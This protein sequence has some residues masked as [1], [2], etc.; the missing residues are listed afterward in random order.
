MKNLKE[1]SRVFILRSKV[2]SVSCILSIGLAVVL[3]ISMSNFVMNAQDSYRQKLS[4][5]YGD[6]DVVASY[7]GYSSIGEEAIQAIEAMEDVAGTGAGRAGGELEINGKKVYA[8][9]V[10]D[11]AMMKSRYRYTVNLEDNQIAVNQVLAEAL[12]CKAGDVLEIAGKRI[13]VRQIIK[14][15]SSTG[16]AAIALMNMGTLSE[17]TEEEEKANFIMIKVK[18]GGSIQGVEKELRI[19][20][21]RLEL[22]VVEGDWVFQETFQAFSGFLVILGIMVLLTAGFMVLGIFRGFLYKYNQDMAVIRAMGGSASQVKRIFLRAALLLNGAGCLLGITLAAAVNKGMLKFFDADINLTGYHARFY[23]FRSGIITL[24]I[25][26]WVSFM[27][28]F[29]ISRNLKILPVAA[30]RDNERDNFGKKKGMGRKGKRR[31]K[32]VFLLRLPGRDFYISV[33]LLAAKMKENFFM[34]VVLG[35]IVLFSLAGA[36]LNSVI[37]RNNSQYVKNQYLTDTVVSSSSYISYG[38]TMKIYDSLKSTEGIDASLVLI[39][40]DEAEVDKRKVSYQL[41][42]LEA[43]EKQGIFDD[44]I[45]EENRMVISDAL[46]KELDI[47]A[48]DIVDITSP[49]KFIRDER[50]FRT[51]Y[52]E[53]PQKAALYVSAVVPQSRLSYYDMYINMDEREFFQEDMGMSKIYISGDRD[54]A[55]SVLAELKIKYQGLKWSNYEEEL[56]LGQKVL[57]KHL[58][59]FNSVIGLLVAIAGIGWLHSVRTMIVSRR[60]EYAILRMQGLSVRRLKKVI[61]LQILLYLFAGFGAGILTGISV[62]ALML[63]WEQGGEGLLFNGDTALRL[64]LFM[65]MLCL[66]LTPTVNKLSREKIKAG[67]AYF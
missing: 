37:S 52:K 54:K 62:T 32:A 24:G 17:L 36:S 38:E 67:R 4:A 47:K 22:T 3:I 49:G 13:T 51:G 12:G 43:M 31:G 55:D 21:P 10:N 60:R 64:L 48:G 5:E 15:T 66:L 53:E 18:E 28:F 33:K 59:I 23:P 65:F 57:D 41:A 40:G 29:S 30:I 11:N 42:D 7:S 45:M 25:F 46:A 9:G 56:D 6:C 14:N 19:Q 61:F 1:I 26:L 58:E 27:L 8:I 63:Y 50:G 2:L 20:Y 39:N 34:T 44:S 35:L 16:S